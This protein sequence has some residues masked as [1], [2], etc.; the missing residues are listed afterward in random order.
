MNW[1][2]T[3]F[4]SEKYITSQGGQLFFRGIPQ[5]FKNLSPNTPNPIPKFPKNTA[6][7]LILKTLFLTIERTQTEHRCVCNVPDADNLHEI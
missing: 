1:F 6:N 3:H 7:F 2:P 5:I 4:G